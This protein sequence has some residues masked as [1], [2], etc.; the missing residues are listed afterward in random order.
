MSK[1]SWTQVKAVFGEAAE[2]PVNER[3]A[4]LDT[5][6]VNETSLRT[7]VNELLAAHD[8]AGEFLSEPTQ[9]EGVNDDRT[10][11][12]SLGGGAERLG[13]KIDRYKLLQCI[14]E[15]GFGVVYMAEQT[16]PVKRR[17]ALKII[18]LGMDTRQV[19]ARFE[20]ERQALAM[21]DHPNIAKVLDAGATETGR[22]YFV[23]DLVKGISLT[24]YCDSENLTMRQRLELFMLV[25]HAV[26]H[27]HQKGIIHRDIKP[28]NVMVTLHDGTPVPKVIDFGIAKATNRELTDKTMFTEFH[29]LIG[30]PAYMSPEQA[31]MSGLDLDTRTDIY[32]LGVLLYELLIGVTPLDLSTLR[33]K[34]FGDIQRIICDVEP[35]K[36]STKLGTLSEQLVTV[37]RQRRTE[38]RALKKMIRGDLDWIVMKAMEK[39]RTR[40]YASASEFASD[41]ARHLNDEPVVARPPTAA[42]LFSKFVRKNR[43]P[44]TAAGAVFVTVVLLGSVALWQSRIAQLR[45]VQVRANS[46]LASAAAA[47]DPMLKALLIAEVAD[48]TELPGRLRIAREAADF[49]LPIAVLRGHEW[50]LTTAGFS[51]DGTRV[52]T[53]SRDG[54]ARLWS[55]DG[56]SKSIV[57]RG[58]VHG[59]WAF[60]SD[61][62]HAIHGGDD[63]SARV[64]QTDGAGKPIILR[65]HE[66]KVSCAAFSSDGSHVITGSWDTT[67]RVWR[68][69]QP[70]EPMVL[71]GHDSMIIS[72]AF[73]PDGSRVVT[74]SRDETARV[75][76]VDKD[77]EPLILRGHKDYVS[78]AAFS[79]DG[80]RVAT[81]SWD[82]TVR[83]WRSD[84]KF[85]PI[86]LRGHT[87]VVRTVTFS[88]DGMHVVSASKDGTARVWQIDGQL[89]FIVL[90]GHEA[91]LFSAEFNADGNRVA[92]A[93]GDGTARVWQADG[94][95]SAIVYR[96]HNGAVVSAVFSPN[97]TQLVTASEDSTARI[98]NLDS[99]G[100]CLVY[101]GHKDMVTC[102]AFSANGQHF[103]TGSWDGTARIWL[104]DVVGVPI[105]LQGHKGGVMAVAFTLDGKSVLTA[106][107][108]GAVRRWRVD[109]PNEPDILRQPETGA[110]SV[111]FDP[112][113]VYAITGYEDGT[114]RLWRTD[115]TGEPTI[116]RGH[117]FGVWGVAFSRDGTHIVTASTDG[118]AIVWRI[119][120]TG[121]PV[122]FRG[123]LDE[124]LSASFS[125][126]GLR[127]VTASNDSTARVWR[128]SDASEMAVLRG[129]NSPVSSAQ[130]SPD[131]MSIVTT[132]YVDGLVRVWNADG[133]GEVLI[134]RGPEPAS[135]AVFSQDGTR[136]AAGFTDGSIRV[137]RITCSGLEKYFRETV[138]VCLTPRER[139]RF[140]AESS[141][142]AWHAYN[143]CERDS[144]RKPNLNLREGS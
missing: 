75:W 144:G 82:G 24:D 131:G 48:F 50:T 25:C 122:I 47:E 67:A 100:E 52:F 46:I 123:H 34:S 37:A 96:G 108:D 117:K 43:V 40:R 142:E 13:T 66:E 49:P 4:F 14:G 111:A 64:W 94:K 76:R 15:G 83:I 113:G 2:L 120:G 90:R 32:S 27:A 9:G 133:T 22:P 140:L 107:K 17:V 136:V 84:Q 143:K 59:V 115:G 55:T 127:V 137:W 109:R 112:T 114:A 7:Q 21:M 68:L 134:L 91:Q 132:S 51:S 101:E 99:V 61:G 126:N 129:H 12:I 33:G 31:E 80:A 105:V 62:V 88:P 81:S 5:M 18:K 98:W 128:S 29:Q 8:E 86:V 71:R 106:A 65:G 38:P 95:G 124:V 102:A 26:Q 3:A 141:S 10:K 85:E 35:S 19:I 54:T 79:P 44:V 87:D 78:D 6:C 92:T 103:I 130:F 30:T 97:G 58:Q 89:P 57:L 125:P 56:N 121:E 23:M 53:A 93:S 41:I 69:D 135:C 110:Q 104:A 119:D 63:N 77:S 39:V 11:T 36:P 70:G 116:L 42:Y 45:A 60:S 138:R 118:T 16:E 28:S 72:V 74:T 20:A 1:V 73:S 139:I